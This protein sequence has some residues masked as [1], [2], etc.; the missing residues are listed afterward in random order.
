[1]QRR[2]TTTL[3]GNEIGFQTSRSSGPGG[4]N[5]NKTNT[6]VTL[7]FSVPHS[8]VLT[9][10]EKEIILKKMS[11]RLTSTGEI[12]I[13]SQEKRSQL[14]NKEEVIR[15]FELLMVKAFEKRKARK[16]TKPSKASVRKRIESK[17]QHSDKK[18]WRQ[19][20]E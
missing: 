8:A 9:E 20:P 2:I 7:R 5:V 6:K 13:S 1:M 12:L 15:K 14:Q 18:R 10:E 11:T 4:Q 17:K 19:K 16:T 3:L